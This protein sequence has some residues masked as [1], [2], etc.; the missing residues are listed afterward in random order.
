MDCAACGGGLNGE[1]APRTYSPLP[2]G[3]SFMPI[4]RRSAPSTPRG[5]AS[6][7]ASFV[8]LRHRGGSGAHSPLLD[9]SL[10]DGSALDL[11]SSSMDATA[12]LRWG[13]AGDLTRQLVHGESVGAESGSSQLPREW[14]ALDR[15]ALLC[16]ECCD[17]VRCGVD[18]ARLWAAREQALYACVLGAHRDTKHARARTPLSPRS[19]TTR[20]GTPPPATPPGQRAAAHEEPSNPLDWAFACDYDDSP[21]SPSPRVHSADF[22]ADAFGRAAMG[23]LRGAGGRPSLLLGARGP[24]VAL[25]A[26]ERERLEAR[27]VAIRARRRAV[28]TVEPLRIVALRA[29]VDAANAA[30]W[31][32]HGRATRAAGCLLDFR[33]VLRLQRRHRERRRAARTSSG[34]SAPRHP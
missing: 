26:D 31:Q 6:V 30:L 17:F 23:A 29:E 16:A 19:P 20:T 4:A 3:E 13:R 27:L 10:L 9:A 7:A 2:L 33:T 12:A 28:D 8:M 5:S 14:G 21:L 15:D 22:A 11:P 34:R 18:A 24:G 32:L 1:S 25:N